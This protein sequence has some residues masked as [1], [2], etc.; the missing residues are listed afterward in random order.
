MIFEADSKLEAVAQLKA[1]YD[2]DL[3]QHTREH[4]QRMIERALLNV[5]GERLLQVTLDGR[6]WFCDSARVH[7]GV[8][9]A[10]KI[11]LGM[12]QRSLIA[13]PEELPVQSAV[14]D[15][16]VLH[17]VHEYSVDPHQV[18]REAARVLRP[19]GHM[20]LL[21]FNPWSMFG[22]HSRLLRQDSAPWNGHFLSPHRLGDWFKLLQL[23]SLT[24]TSSDYHYPLEN[25][26]WRRRLS[27][28][29]ALVKLLPFK[30]G[31]LFLMT[32]RKDVAGMT[33]LQPEWN[34]R[35]LRKLQVIESKATR[36]GARRN[37][38]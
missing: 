9:V 12:K 31:N 6:S 28:V 37:Q 19:G 13:T 14:I 2:T 26:V 33:P 27:K 3:G 10:P 8:L 18:L 32:A 25:R 30:T 29:S 24:L 17:H 1:W 36:A 20:I 23:S 15:V 22:V 4:E 16:L 7:H 11:E 35:L 5:Q 21:G 34:R 38:S